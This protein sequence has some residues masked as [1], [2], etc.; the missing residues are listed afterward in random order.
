MLNG[1]DTRAK[2][3]NPKLRGSGWTEDL[4]TRE[5]PISDGKITKIGNIEKRGKP[6]FADYILGYD[7]FPIAV[8]EAKSGDHSPD[9]GISQ[10]KDYANRFDIKFAYSSNG[11][12]IV[13]YRKA[14]RGEL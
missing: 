2:L 13:E 14:F 6:L 4:I 1:A 10:A 12:S 8:V 3:I 5:Y 11:H 7:N 9:A